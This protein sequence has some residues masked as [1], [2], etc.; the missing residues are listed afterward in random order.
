[1]TRN[2]AVL[3]S[4]LLG[5]LLATGIAASAEKGSME[6]T[7]TL[8]GELVDSR[9]YLMQGKRGGEHVKCAVACAKDGLPI[10][11]VDVKGRYYT[12]VIQANQIADS[13]GLQAEVEGILKGDSIVPTRIKVNKEGTWTEINL[14][15]QM[16]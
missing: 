13:S 3:L 6:K 16:M 10:G 1:M 7:A 4:A 9:C 8:K 15:E 12:L 11:L 14:P 5:A 2:K